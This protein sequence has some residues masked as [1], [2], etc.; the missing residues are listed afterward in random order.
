MQQQQNTKELK[1][2]YCYGWV[3]ADMLLLIGCQTCDCLY[4]VGRNSTFVMLYLIL[5]NVLTESSLIRNK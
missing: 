1:Y 3:P 2:N 4:D 5:N